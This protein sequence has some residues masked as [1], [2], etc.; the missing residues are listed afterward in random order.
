MPSAGAVARAAGQPTMDGTAL[1]DSTPSSTAERDW[2]TETI[3]FADPGVAVRVAAHV[4]GRCFSATVNETHT[5]RVAISFDGGST[6]T[7]GNAPQV[8]PLDTGSSGTGRITVAASHYR[9]GTPTG[10][11]VIKVRAQSSGSTTPVASAGHLTAW[12]VPE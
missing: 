9:T 3:T 10:D 6:F 2:G 7:F 5:T 11:I 4:T 12:M 8:T 1:T